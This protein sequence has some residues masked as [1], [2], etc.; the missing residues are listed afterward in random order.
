M[1]INNTFIGAISQG[2][3]D[4]RRVRDRFSLA[5]GVAEEILT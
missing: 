4:A 2:T 3:G 5:E 1:T